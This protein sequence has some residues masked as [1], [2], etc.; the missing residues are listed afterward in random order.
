MSQFEAINTMENLTSFIEQNDVALV[1]ISRENCS[2]CHSLKPQIQHI[3]DKYPKIAT[4]EVSA[5]QVPEVAG[6]F[7]IFTVPVVL[8][9]VDN[10]EFY[11]GAR[12]VPLD[13]FEATVK[14]IYDGYFE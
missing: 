14:Q 5:D 13:R 9:F 4:S 8:L 2:V 7:S 1:Y 12:I 3:M 11:R 6:A 10:K